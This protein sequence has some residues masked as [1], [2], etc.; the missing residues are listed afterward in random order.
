MKNYGLRRK[1]AKSVNSVLIHLLFS[2]NYFHMIVSSAR[3]LISLQRRQT[4]QLFLFFVVVV[5]V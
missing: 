5:A 4:K 3:F 2:P 1:L